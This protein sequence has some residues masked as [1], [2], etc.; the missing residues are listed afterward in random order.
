[1]RISRLFG[2]ASALLL[3]TCSAGQALAQD[4]PGEVWVHLDAPEG[5]VL[6][7]DTTNDDD[8]ETVCR[9]PCDQR[10]STAFNYRVTGGGIKASADFT[11]YRAPVTRVTL[12]VD[13]ASKTESA[14]GLVGVA[15]GAVALPVGLVIWFFEALHDSFQGGSTTAG[16]EATMAIGAVA[17]VGGLGLVIANRRTEVRQ[18]LGANEARVPPPVA[19]SRAPVWGAASQEQR[20]LPP[21]VGVPIFGGRF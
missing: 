17:L 20:R 10:L 5:V 18:D 16:G 14:V 9:A 7:R 6:Q 8:W 4:T 2:S 12:V 11:L 21:V 3:V 1:M 15:G 13:G 19:W